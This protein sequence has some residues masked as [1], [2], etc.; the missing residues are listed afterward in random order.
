[1]AHWRRGSRGVE[2]AA[3]VPVHLGGEGGRGEEGVAVRLRTDQGVAAS[4][5]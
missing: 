3:E 2:Q 5:L 4:A 1:M